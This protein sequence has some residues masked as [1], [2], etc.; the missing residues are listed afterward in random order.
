MLIDDFN[1]QGGND[2]GGLRGTYQRFPS[3]AAYSIVNQERRGVKGKVLKIDYDKK[4]SGW[5]GYYT[6]LKVND[7]YFDASDYKGVAFWVKGEKGGETFQVGFADKRWEMKDDSAKSGG[8]EDYL[9]GHVTR[10]WQFVVFPFVDFGYVKKSLLYSL[11]VN[12]DQENKG[13]VYIS[14]ISFVKK[15]PAKKKKSAT[16]NAVII[17]DFKSL[18]H[19]LLGGRSGSFSR[20]PSKMNISIASG[21]GFGGRGNALKV[22]YEKGEFGWCGCYSQMKKGGRYFDAS[23]YRFLTFYVRGDN[24]GEDFEVGLSDRRYDLKENSFSAGAVS[25]Y[26]PKGVTKSWQKVKIPFFDFTDIDFDKMAST[27]FVFNRGN[28]TVYLSELAFEK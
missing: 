19:N 18:D 24:G 27:V 1:F 7:T 12:F 10:D 21:Q 11:V 17:D 28:G 23:E 6:I 14:G 5:C 3:R 25:N 16:A 20:K 13:A 15:L 9:G 2:L 22:E 8:V 26:L 4:E